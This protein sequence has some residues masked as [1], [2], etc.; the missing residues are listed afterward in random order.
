M[1]LKP[2]WCRGG[3]E[4]LGPW[5]EELMGELE[6]ALDNPSEELCYKRQ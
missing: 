6:T 2:F 1:N 3:H 4:G 5:L